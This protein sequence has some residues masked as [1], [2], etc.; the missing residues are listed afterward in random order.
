MLC[1]SVIALESLYASVG[2]D[3]VADDQGLQSEW[4]LLAS[5]ILGFGTHK[6]ENRPCLRLFR[7][8]H[9]FSQV[10]NRTTQTGRARDCLTH[11]PH[12]DGCFL[13]K[14]GDVI[15][16]PRRSLAHHNFR[17]SFGMCTESDSQWL[18]LFTRLSQDE[19]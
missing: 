5:H 3:F 13:T 19:S 4:H 2:I 1:L 11:R 14:T 7:A 17:M 8:E 12:V 18:T 9:S 15:F 6:V 10:Y 16:M